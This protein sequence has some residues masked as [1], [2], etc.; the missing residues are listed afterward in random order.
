MSRD[1]TAQLRG[2]EKTMP[3]WRRLAP[4]GRK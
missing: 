3:A 2:T 1:V 4:C